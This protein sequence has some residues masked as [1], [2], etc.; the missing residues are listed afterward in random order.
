MGH[1]LQEGQAPHPHIPGLEPLLEGQLLRPAEQGPLFRGQGELD[2]FSPALQYRPGQL[3]R[4]LP[5][6]GGLL[7]PLPAPVLLGLA[8]ED[9]R[10]APLLG[11]GTQGAGQIPLQIAGPLLGGALVDE[12]VVLQ[13]PGAVLRRVLLPP[14]RGRLQKGQEV[15]VP[16]QLRVLPGQTVSEIGL[17]ILVQL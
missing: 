9:Q 4:P 1:P 17:Q 11:P 3:P 2:L 8:A 10:L 15:P 5:A 12:A 16:G 13:P 6:P 14:L 7:I